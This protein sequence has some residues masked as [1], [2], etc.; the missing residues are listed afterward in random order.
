M[1]AAYIMKRLN[2]RLDSVISISQVAYQKNRS[3]TEPI[4]ATKLII[5]STISSTN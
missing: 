5:E 3:T 2:S 4:F 1:L